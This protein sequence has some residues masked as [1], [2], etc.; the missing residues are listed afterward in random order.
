MISP[1]LFAIWLWLGPIGSWARGRESESSALNASAHGFEG[2]DAPTLGLYSL[3]IAGRLVNGKECF[4][5]RKMFGG[6]LQTAK[7]SFFRFV[8][9][10]SKGKKTRLN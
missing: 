10:S 8:S 7:Q 2:L 3:A 6:L 5:Q 9:T 4:V 1:L